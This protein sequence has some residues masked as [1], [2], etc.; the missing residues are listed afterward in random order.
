MYHEKQ[1]YV[2]TMRGIKCPAVLIQGTKKAY[3]NML[4][5]FGTRQLM[6]SFQENVD[7]IFLSADLL[8]R[9]HQMMMQMMMTEKV[10][11]CF[12]MPLLYVERI[13]QDIKCLIQS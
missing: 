11:A 3:Q 9:W 1:S 4:R 5:P 2:K 8:Q 7:A 10:E 12:D 6:P 13:Q